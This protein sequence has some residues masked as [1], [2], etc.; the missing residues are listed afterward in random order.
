[1]A[2]WQLGLLLL[3]G[4]W[5]LQSVG[6]WLQMRHYARTV[7]SIGSEF[8]E[9]FLGTGFVRGRFQKGTIALVVVSDDLVV[10]RVSTMTGRSV[11]AKFHS[12][13]ALAG[14]RLDRLEAALSDVEHFDAGR[15]A[16]IL[17]AVAQIETRRQKRRQED[18][19][20]HLLRLENA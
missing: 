17:A 14:L 9:G 11:F 1:M 6:V 20:S 4:A 8:D 10:R 16:A 12:H 18:T 13:P 5:A 15:T 7:K 2:T 19:G 3:V